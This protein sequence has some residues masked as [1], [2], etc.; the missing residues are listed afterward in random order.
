M[1]KNSHDQSHNKLEDSKNGINILKG[2][3]TEKRPL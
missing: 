1:D 3:P 2:K